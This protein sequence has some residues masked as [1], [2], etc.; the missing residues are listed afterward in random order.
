MLTLAEINFW[1]PLDRNEF[2]GNQ[3]EMS[4]REIRYQSRIP[5]VHF[6]TF[7]MKCSNSKCS[8]FILFHY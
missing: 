8:L 7:V 6:Y 3:I 4:L 2:K 5:F 1:K